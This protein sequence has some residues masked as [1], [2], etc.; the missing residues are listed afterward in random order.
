[1]DFYLPDTEEIEI[2]TMVMVDLR[3]YDRVLG[4]EFPSNL[5][6]FHDRLRVRVDIRNGEIVV[7]PYSETKLALRLGRP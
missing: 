7:V 2:T 4:A 5:S 6:C 1:M 3:P